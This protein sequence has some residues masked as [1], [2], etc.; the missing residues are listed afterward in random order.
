MIHVLSTTPIANSSGHYLNDSI[1]IELDQD[2]EL[3]YLSSNYINVWETNQGQTEFYNKILVGIT[4]GTG[5]NIIKITPN[6]ILESVSYYLVIITGGSGG[7][8][9]ITSD[10]LEN[11]YTLFFQSGNSVRPTT[12]LE[13][14]IEGIDLFIDGKEDGNYDFSSDAFSTASSDARIALVETIPEDFSIGVNNIDTIVYIYNDD[15]YNN[16][17]SNVLVGSYSLLP[18][19]PD[20][21][22]DRKIQSSGVIVTE[23]SAAFLI[24]EI[25]GEINREYNF[26]LPANKVRGIEREEYDNEDR[27]I[28]FMTVLEPVYASPDQISLRLK[29]FNLDA[30]ISITEYEIYK[31]ILEKSLY[32]RDEIGIII[33]S[34]NLAQINRLVIC[35][36]LK[37]IIINSTLLSG[38]S[39][40]SRMLML[41]EVVYENYD[42]KD[43]L[44]ALD[45]CIK[46]NT[47]ADSNITFVKHGIKSGKWLSRQGKNYNVYR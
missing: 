14:P 3:S 37:D 26:K 40:K 27:Y 30:S 16:I 46:E 36:V 43:I 24:P 1:F 15:V 23:H 10:T 19:D 18:M 47:P 8:Q 44:K 45:D 41:N 2:I 22:G 9:S 11:N 12:T 20:P 25:S 28:R 31:L 5:Q 4:T 42:I 32:V 21:F 33:D 29:G 35:L 6:P 38:G 13:D 34:S 17:P 7:I 39:I